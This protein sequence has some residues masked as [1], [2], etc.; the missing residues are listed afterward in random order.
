MW[1]GESSE[2][3]RKLFR[4]AINAKPSI[5]FFD[6]LDG[7]CPSRDGTGMSEA[8]NSVVTTLL[9]LMD[10]LPVGE[11]FVFGATNRV[12]SVDPAMLRPGRFDKHLE[13]FPPGLEAR[14]QII[15]ITTSKW[16]RSK[17]SGKDLTKFGEKTVG[18]T[19]ADIEKLCREA[20]FAAFDRHVPN[21][22]INGSIKDMEVEHNFKVN[23]LNVQSFIY[24][25]CIQIL[26]SD[27]NVAFSNTKPTNTAVFGSTL[28]IPQLP[29]PAVN[30]LF[31]N[32]QNQAIEKLLSILPKRSQAAMDLAENDD[33]SAKITTFLLSSKN[34]FSAHAIE[35]NLLPGI[36]VH[37]KIADY[38]VYILSLEN[39]LS[40]RTHKQLD[41]ITETV[42]QVLNS[43][44]PCILYMPR[45]EDLAS[46]Y[47]A[48][49]IARQLL[50]LRGKPVLLLAT[51]SE[52]PAEHHFRTIFGA[53]NSAFAIR[54]P[55]QQERLDFFRPMFTTLG[56]RTEGTV[57]NITDAM[58]KKLDN[59][60]KT[61]AEVTKESKVDL[62]LSLH[63][64]LMK[65]FVK[66]FNIKDKRTLPGE[67]GQIL[68]E[69]NSK[70]F[71]F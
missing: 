62:V 2:N 29:N 44:K 47:L 40:R 11:V 39:I 16:Y 60:H 55:N 20:F 36:L 24:I 6:E 61:A 15:T 31:T 68:N 63:D 4:D 12:E 7:L 21:A 57:P 45:L 19:G 66:Y 53:S 23:L 32:I 8:N 48:P 34:T 54:L 69:Y 5:I 3:L 37:P 49:F 59:L 26:E 52:L 9:G 13:F 10:T 30:S 58:K 27:W 18:Y 33:G 46:N 42:N 25:V 70:K 41:H 22:D 38:P 67:L 17:P 28:Y 65:V 14:K 50:Q 35:T 43:V 1:F 64:A 71:M 56:H 51:S